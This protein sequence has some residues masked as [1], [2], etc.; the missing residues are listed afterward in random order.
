MREMAQVA[1]QAAQT[2]RQIQSAIS[3]LNRLADS[4][5]IR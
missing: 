4:V 1:T 2:S 5:N 3:E